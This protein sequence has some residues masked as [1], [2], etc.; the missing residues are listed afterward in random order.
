MNKELANAKPSKHITQLCMDPGPFYSVQPIDWEY[1][2]YR[3]FG[4]GYDVE[5]SGMDTGSSRKLATIYLWYQKTRI[6]KTIYHVHQDEISDRVDELYALTQQGELAIESSLLSFQSVL[7]H[8]FTGEPM[9]PLRCC[10]PAQCHGSVATHGSCHGVPPTVG[11]HGG[12]V[13]VRA[14]DIRII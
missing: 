3:D 4:N 11:E 14:C 12:S 8:A 2:I 1:V 6:A 9:C 5:V 7:S 10:M 13:G